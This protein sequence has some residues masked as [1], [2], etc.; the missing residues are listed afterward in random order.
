MRFHPTIGLRVGAETWGLSA[1]ARRRG[2]GS[3]WCRWAAWFQSLN[4][5]VGAVLLF[6]GTAQ[7]Q[8]SRLLPCAGEG[9]PAPS[10]VMACC[11]S[12]PTPRSPT[13]AAAKVVLT[14]RFSGRGRIAKSCRATAAALLHV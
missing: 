5:S 12:G 8:A 14:Q 2:P 11:S 1:A 6:E 10:G 3:V 9:V 13:G 7:R 4:V